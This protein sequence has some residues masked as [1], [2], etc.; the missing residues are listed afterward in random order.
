MDTG[1]LGVSRRRVLAFSAASA[2][3]LAFSARGQ[4][5]SGEGAK[6]AK[7]LVFEIADKWTGGAIGAEEQLRAAGF[8]VETLPLD[9][10]PYMLDA[11]LI[12]LGSFV[13]ESPEYKKYV[14][15]YGKELYRFADRGKVLVQMA[16]A[17]QTEGTPPFLPSTHGAKR[18]D[19][20]F[21]EAVILSA[22]HPLMKGVPHAK[23]VVK[24][25][26]GDRRTIW[27]S[28]AEQEGFEVIMAAEADAAHPALMEGAYGQGRIILSAMDFDKNKIAATG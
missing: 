12:F 24:W 15:E 26:R 19:A 3:A 21:G 8:V 10:S 5:K 17:D 13:S 22:E 1:E 9:R 28:L 18:V 23:G 2:A 25:A 27:E 7:A 20:D 16:Q 6:P 11:D 4:E 14:G